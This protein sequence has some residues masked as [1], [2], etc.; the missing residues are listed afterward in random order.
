M[1]EPPLSAR[2]GNGCAQ[3]ADASHGPRPAEGQAQSRESGGRP[4]AARGGGARQGSG[5]ARSGQIESA[6]LP[7]PL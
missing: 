2:G 1:G 7:W 3:N 5:I 6:E 4:G